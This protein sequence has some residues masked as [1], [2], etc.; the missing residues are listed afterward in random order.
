M[1]GYARGSSVGV[2]KVWEWER[3]DGG[4]SPFPPQDSAHIEYAYNMRLR[5]FPL[6][7]LGQY[8]VDFDRMVQRNNSSS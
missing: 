6:G 4:Y 7:S 2:G 3:D 8:T 1:A 5:T